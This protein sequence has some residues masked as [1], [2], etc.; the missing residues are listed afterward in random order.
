MAVHQTADKITVITIAAI[1]ETA[2]AGTVIHKDMLKQQNADG[3][4]VDTVLQEVAMT[5]TEDTAAHPETVITIMRMTTEEE[6]IPAAAI[7]IMMMTTEDLDTVDGLET[8]KDIQKLRNA[9]GKTEV[10]TAAVAIT[11]EVTA[12][13]VTVVIVV[14][15]TTMAAIPETDVAGMVIHKDMP[16]QPTKV[17][18]TVDTKMNCKKNRSNFR[19]IFF[20]C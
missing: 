1:P 20:K 7:T 3:N 16:K 11:T 14:I 8:L 10:V 6:V 9:D 15:M 13:V 2:V 12:V 5:M 17:G 19:A 4:I 18:E